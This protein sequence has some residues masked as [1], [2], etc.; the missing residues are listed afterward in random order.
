MVH[1]RRKAGSWVE[2]VRGWAGARR[3]EAGRGLL[4]DVL[5]EALLDEHAVLAVGVLR[6]EMGWV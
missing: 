3:L 1:T 2:E 4:R 5:P 6:R